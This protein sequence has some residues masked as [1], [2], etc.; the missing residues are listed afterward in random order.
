[1][2][3]FLGWRYTVAVFRYQAFSKVVL[4]HRPTF[5]ITLSLLYRC[6]GWFNVEYISLTQPT[7]IQSNLV[8]AVAQ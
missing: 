5:V 4:K 3:I 2:I 8:D 7:L 6:I 1:M